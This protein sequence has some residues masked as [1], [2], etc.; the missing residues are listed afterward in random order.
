MSGKEKGR[1]GEPSDKKQLTMITN[2]TNNS[3]LDKQVNVG[4]AVAF[5]SNGYWHAFEN[6]KML[7]T[8]YKEVSLKELAVF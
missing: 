2:M 3:N 6:G 5:W 4:K 8:L 7:K 1:Q